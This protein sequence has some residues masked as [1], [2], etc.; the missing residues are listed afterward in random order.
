MRKYIVA[1]ITLG[2]L[3]AVANQAIDDALQ[4]TVINGCLSSRRTAGQIEEWGIPDRLF[5]EPLFTNLVSVLR[6]ELASCDFAYVNALTGSVK[7]AAFV[8]A[9]TKCGNDAYH[10]SLVRWFGQGMSLVSANVMVCDMFLFPV[11]TNMEDYMD[12]H[13]DAPGVS[14]VLNNVKHLYQIAG[15]SANVAAIDWILS[16]NSKTTK[17]EAVRNGLIDRIRD[18]SGDS[19]Q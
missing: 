19:Q 7:R 5:R 11:G 8:A 12:M 14:N 13:F 3:C 1:I 4:E 16:G 10:D 18:G 9:L 2:S 15:D 17:M 6:R